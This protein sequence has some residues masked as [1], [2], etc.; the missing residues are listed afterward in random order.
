MN[1]QPMFHPFARVIHWLMAAMILAMLFIG[2]GMVSTV[3]EKHQWLVGIHKPLGI[4]VFVLA[5]VRLGFRLTHPAPPLPADLPLWQKL[6]AHASHWLLYALMLAMPLIGW[7]MLSAGGYPVTLGAGLQ[8]PAILPA[9]ATLFAWLRESHRYLAWLFFL[10][11]LA[12]M[13]AALMH[14]LIRRDGVL[15]S[16]TGGGRD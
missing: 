1:G 10:T 2:A 5:L 8:L 12:H 7:G 15:R 9:D 14:G 3:S 13:G 11:F 4:A 16:M 6:A